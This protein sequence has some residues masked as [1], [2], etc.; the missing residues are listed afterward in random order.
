MQPWSQP[1]LWPGIAAS[2]GDPYWSNVVLLM[3]YEGVNG[4]QTAPGMNDESPSAHGTATVQGTAAIATAQFKFGASSLNIPA[5]TKIQFANS[6]DWQ[7]G[8]GNFT[9][10]GWVYPV[11]DVGGT[12]T[13]ISLWQPGQLSWLLFTAITGDHKFHWSTST[14]GSAVNADITGATTIVTSTWYHLAIDFDG[15]KY[16]LYLNGVMDGSFSTPRTLFASTAALTMGTS[17]GASGNQ[18]AGNLDEMRITK[19]I[20]RY[21]SDAGFAVPTA[22]FPR[23]A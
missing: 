4:S 16:R 18:L 21:A 8:S 14:N 5:S 1:L 2:P 17:N 23:H 15:S 13:V 12:G 22:A 20:A 7:F 10:E 19:G 3:G 9:I 6:A 11:N